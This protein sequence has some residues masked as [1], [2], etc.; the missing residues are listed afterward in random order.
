M[1]SRIGRYLFACILLTGFAGKAQQ[2][3]LTH[4]TVNDGMVSNAVRKIFQDSRGF[5]WIATMEGLSKYDGRRFINYSTANGM[6]HD[7]VNDMLETS[8]G[9]LIFA[10]NDGS[11]IWMKHDRIENIT[12]PGVV[13]NRFYRATSGKVLVVTDRQGIQE[14]NQGN[15]YKPPQA[16]PHINYFSIA[17]VND[18]LL[19]LG[20]DSSVQL[21]TK[22]YRLVKILNHKLIN[23]G[24][25]KVFKDSKG[26]LWTSNLPGLAML[27]IE[28]QTP[29]PDVL[30]IY[31]L[32]AAPMEQIF[33]DKKGN[34][35]FAGPFGLV[36]WDRANGVNVFGKKNGLPSDQVTCIFEDKENNFWIGTYNGLCKIQA[37]SA[38]NRFD[39]R[40]E[41][42]A[43][44]FLFN[45]D[46]KRLMIG[47]RMGSQYY[48]KRTGELSEIFPTLAH[49]Y[50]TQQ[51][52]EGHPLLLTDE[53][54]PV[55]QS[56]K[57]GS[58][59]QRFLS[60]HPSRILHVTK[61][62]SC[63]FFMSDVFGFYIYD[64]QKVFSNFINLHLIT[65]L[66]ADKKGGLW[67]GIWS[68]G[69]IKIQYE[70]KNGVFRILKKDTLLPGIG[71]RSVLQDKEGNIWAGTRYNGLFRLSRDSGE[72]Y[73][74]E[75]WNNE[76]GLSSNW[77]H[78]L[79]EDEKGNIW[80]AY[81]YGLDKLVKQEDGSWRVFNF[82]RVNNFFA[83]IQHI[84]PDGESSFWLTTENN[85]LVYLQDNE[86]EKN[87]PWPV[88]ITTLNIGDSLYSPVTM[89]PELSYRRNSLRI[90]FT[91]PTFINEQQVLYSY[92]LKGSGDTSWTKAGN[93]QSVSFAS[94]RPG[95]YQFEVRTLGWNGQWGNPS[96]FKFRILPPLWQRDWFIA[97]CFLILAAIIA[98]I[99]HR[100]I[101][102]IRKESEMRQ[103]LSETEMMALRAQMN[104]H[105]LFNSLN[106][107]DSLIQTHQH[108]KATTY[109]GRFARL[110]R[111]VLV[112]SK[113]KQVPF[114]SDFTAMQLYL[115][116][117]KFRSTGKFQF[118]I[119]AEPELLNGGY[120]IPPL[121][122]QP[123][124][125]NA[126][127]HGL[128]NKQSDDRR[129]TVKAAL[130]D[131]FIVFNIT[132]NGVGRARANELKVLNKPEHISYGW[133]ITAQ[134][135]ALHNGGKGEDY[136]IVRDLFDSDGSAG[137]SVTLKIKVTPS[138]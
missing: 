138:K 24:E 69:L 30:R 63:L 121:L 83:I 136:I 51:N 36:K 78:A 120:S 119:S 108:D 47:T 61:D 117:E 49:P 52:I 7:M 46:D 89:P 70:N 4:Y 81:P 125:E 100:R 93:T 34:M 53:G 127:Y 40:T 79:T 14:F 50:V 132:D 32:S 110:L 64:R 37:N 17:A 41:T 58:D 92:R 12:R 22:D 109:L 13:I 18:S 42:S 54:K 102:Y 9:K 11:L 57:E 10:C 75:Q 91:A 101:K 28:G 56:T 113:N 84:V 15:L 44:N 115:D 95:K 129:L 6:P 107:I 134:R 39:L 82:S 94:L 71:I 29:L 135:L 16:F 123:F 66:A 20:S 130:Q 25:N 27:S 116:M 33:E 2:L 124:I 104:P 35:W 106:A 19:L 38:I 1:Y 76:K 118:E 55:L 62:S 96:V 137:T 105:F 80:M 85:G 26:H 65:G 103:Q 74:A 48:D 67:I 114:D 126:I 99:V 59:L 128:M 5:L 77:I 133:Q 68:D 73:K 112:S 122:A 88:Y 131:D 31:P 60:Q 45:E 8:D 72:R 43:V 97:V 111:L 87:S 90:D 3:N 21:L 86:R 23:Y 98:F